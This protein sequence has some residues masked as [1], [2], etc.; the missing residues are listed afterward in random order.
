M[1]SGVTSVPEVPLRFYGG[2]L[3]DDTGSGKTLTVLGL[4]CSSPLTAAGIRE[5]RRRFPRTLHMHVECRGTIVICPANIHK[6]WLSE[7]KKA[8]PSMKVLGLSTILDHQKISWRDVMEADLVIVSYQFLVNPN[9]HKRVL[10]QRVSAEFE[11]R[12]HVNDR[13]RVVLEI[14]QFHRAVLDEFHEL[15]S[16]KGSVMQFVSQSLRA[17]F[18]WGLSGTYRP[19]RF[20][21][22][23]LKY[24]PVPTRLSQVIRENE[25]AAAECEFKYV[26][27]NEPQLQLPP[28]V[29]ETVWVDLSARELALLHCQGEANRRSTRD[30][31]MFCS[32]Y[33]L[34]ATA[35]IEPNSFVSIAVAEEKLREAKR[36]EVDSLT[37]SVASSE[38]RLENAELNEEQKRT[39]RNSLVLLRRQLGI[40]Q[41]SYNYFESVFRAICNDAATADGSD[42]CSICHDTIPPA[43][44]AIL[45]CSHLYCYACVEGAIKRNPKCPLCAQPLKQPTD[46]LRINRSANRES[47][48]E[49]DELKH[50]DTSKYSSKMVAVYRY[51]TSLLGAN[52]EGA[53]TRPARIILF[54]QYGDLANFMSESLKQLGVKHVRV[55]GNVFQRQNAIAQFTESE[56]VRL[57]ML[58]SENSVSGINLT[59]A[60]HIILMHPFWSD[61]GEDVDLAYEKQ[62]IS[63]AYRFG[64]QHPLKIVRFAVKGTVEEEI[65]LRRQNLRL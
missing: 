5:R 15:E 33:Q 10:S 46:I 59:Q 36:K 37:R 65:T 27:R 23:G 8:C 38:K 9:Y 3:A 21:S 28:I 16:A 20:L 55:V 63:R 58:S 30:Q 40:A 12:D 4:V 43:D 35:S 31:I 19:G 13:G 56:D 26:K 2:I 25:S 14:C 1:T 41:G 49:Q 44:L 34:T 57:I 61:K 50:L 17:D 11:M 22:V 60:T 53:A 54:L 42:N 24:F 29:N 51:I 62:G 48:A 45:P 64:L 7:T 6:Q 18:T 47:N 32:H 52:D 39:V